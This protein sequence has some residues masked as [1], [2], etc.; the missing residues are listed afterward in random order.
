MKY[1]ILKSLK[2]IRNYCI[3]NACSECIF[4][5][6][7]DDFTSCEIRQIANILHTSPNNWDI[8]KIEELL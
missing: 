1:K 3:S 8:E 4:N 5:I 2:N 6:D 7:K